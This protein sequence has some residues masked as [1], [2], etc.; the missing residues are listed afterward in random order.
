MKVFDLTN[1]EI[2]E[3]WISELRDLAK[4]YAKAKGNRMQLEEFRK[5]RKNTLMK[6]AELDGYNAIGAQEREAYAHP[7]Y[8]RLIHGL[9]QATQAEAEALWKLRIEEMRFEAWRT[10]QANFRAERMRYG[11]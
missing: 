3:G 6:R 9:A 11:T 4:I 7:E 5:V 8:E 10:N 1:D 2:R